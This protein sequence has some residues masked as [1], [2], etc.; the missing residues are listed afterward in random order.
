ME[1]AV[2]ENGGRT[3]G[4]SERGAGECAFGNLPTG[5]EYERSRYHLLLHEIT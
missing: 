1:R 4:V 5:L 2:L 3:P